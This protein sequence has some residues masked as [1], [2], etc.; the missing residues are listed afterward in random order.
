MSQLISINLIDTR[1]LSWN[2]SLIK[3]D[4]FH[5]IKQ[6][7]QLVPVLCVKKNDS[8]LLLDGLQRYQ[9]SKQLG[10]SSILVVV[11]DNES[12]LNQI[13]FQLHRPLLFDSIILR[14][15]FLNTIENLNSNINFDQFRLPNYSHIKKDIKRVC[16]L[17]FRI[18]RD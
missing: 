10:N 16:E 8:Y 14:L 12:D 4:L 6:S 17:D 1:Y 7:G 5:S 13:L 3:D 9:I 15:R 11:I 18:Q 2:I